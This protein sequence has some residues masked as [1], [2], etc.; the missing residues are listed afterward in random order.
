MDIKTLFTGQNNKVSDYETEII[1]NEYIDSETND[2]ISIQLGRIE[3]E[4][5]YHIVLNSTFNNST[6]S[7]SYF[8]YDS[9][10]YFSGCMD[11]FRLYNKIFNTR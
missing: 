2:K 8:G 5:W 6:S 3:S 9:N 1:T 11:D 7:N 4:K 10:N